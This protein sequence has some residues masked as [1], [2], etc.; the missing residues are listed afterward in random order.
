M[1]SAYKKLNS[2]EADATLAESLMGGTTS[3]SE[4]DADTDVESPSHHS[5]RRS[6]TSFAFRQQR[7]PLLGRTR[8]G[9]HRL[10]SVSDDAISDNAHKDPV[11][12][13][14]LT[15]VER[16]I[17]SDIQ[18]TLITQ[19]SSGSYF[20]KNADK[21]IVGVFKPKNEEPYG[22][23]NPKWTKYMQRLC[24]PCMF[25]RPCLVLNQG[26]LSEA[27]AYAV[28]QFFRLGVVPMTKVVQLSSPAFNYARVTRLAEQAVRNASGKFPELGKRLRQGLPPKTG[29]LQVFVNG[30]KDAN[31]WMK[32]WN[33]NELSD[34]FKESFQ[35]QFEAL[36]ALDY[37]IRNTDRGMDN[38]LISCDVP[39]D[40]SEAAPST[41]RVAAIDNGLAFPHKHPDDWRAYPYHWAYLEQSKT[42]F[43]DFTADKLLP[44]LGD[45]KKV[46]ELV[47]QLREMF[48]LDH[49]F[50]KSLF[51][52][53]M[54]VM[55]GQIVNLREALRTRK[56]PLQLVRMPNGTIMIHSGTQAKPNY[57]QIVAKRLPFFRNW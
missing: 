34:E 30:F 11:F 24:C 47:R 54:A 19:G 41:V 52:K 3:A 18:P 27:G 10:N 32:K 29:S 8:S 22:L 16:A 44:I 31:V 36:V 21:K 45:D 14:I 33:W 42:P 35:H 9:R 53:Q 15:S 46:E 55:R 38:W 49:G 12:S 13:A 39:E 6:T 20:T 40:G 57:R 17:D 2:S 48:S 43:S 23:L 7:T 5:K 56:S 1:T 26:Y 51:N 4:A 50:S 37:I 28:D 25:G